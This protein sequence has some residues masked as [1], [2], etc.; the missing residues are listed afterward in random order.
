MI[1]ERPLTPEQLAVHWGCSANHV[2]NLIKRG[3][4]QAFRLG[5]L[6]RIP[7]AAVDEFQQRQMEA[8]CAAIPQTARPAT[9]EAIVL[10]V[11]ESSRR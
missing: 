1:T 7:A 10:R 2:R 3:E 4:L 5:R 11:P 9:Q 6:I 8:D